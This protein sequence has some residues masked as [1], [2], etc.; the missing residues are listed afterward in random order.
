MQ[1]TRNGA[2]HSRS[3]R[4][5]SLRARQLA[6]QLKNLMSLK[7]R[8]PSYRTIGTSGF[9]IAVRRLRWGISALSAQ[10]NNSI[11]RMFAS[12]RRIGLPDRL[13]CR[14]RL[15]RGIARKAYPPRLPPGITALAMGILLV[16]MTVISGIL[17]AWK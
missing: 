14:Q 3:W 4:N 11:G 1:L 8:L 2:N 13:V 7:D 6:V 17:V 10:S 9:G 12:S 15:A 16:L 5:T